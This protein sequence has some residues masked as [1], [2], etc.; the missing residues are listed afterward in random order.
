MISLLLL[1]PMA[2]GQIVAVHLKD[3]RTAKKYKKRLT[4]LNGELVLIGEAKSGITIDPK[5]GK[6]SYSTG[7]IE[8]YVGNP[9]DPSAVPYKLKDGEITSQ[10][11]SGVLAIQGQQIDRV[12]VLNQNQS[13]YGL[14]QEYKRRMELVLEIKEKRGECER[15]STEWHA[16]NR[17]LVHA[18]ERLGSWLVRS[19]YEPASKK[20]ER[21][22]KR[23][24]KYMAERDP[25][26]HLETKETIHFV[27]TS[28]N[29]IDLSEDITGGAA[30]FRIQ[31][32][33]HVRIT[34]MTELPDDL[35]AE[36][37]ELA[38]SVMQGFRTEFVDPY[39]QEGLEDHMPEGVFKEFWFG[40]AE[41][42]QYTRF[43]EEYYGISWGKHKEQRIKP[44][45]ARRRA[46]KGPKY[47]DYWRLMPDNDLE[48]IIVHGMGHALSNVHYNADGKGIPQAWIA[49]GVGYYLSLE[50][51]GRNAVTCKQFKEKGYVRKASNLNPKTAMLGT[52]DF[53]NT[54][55]LSQG[56][57]ID[58]LAMKH[59]SDMGDADLAKSWSFFDFMARKE[60]LR[61]QLWMRSACRLAGKRDTFI[62]NWRAESMELYEVNEG[63][64]FT[65]IEQR[66][67]KYAE[68][69]QDRT[70]NPRLGQAGR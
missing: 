55:A 5:S 15:K 43:F 70:S 10:R 33:K 29:L 31:E 19:G 57:R 41:D 18:Y 44:K 63:N 67:R 36:L 13:L 22:I 47:L 11:K 8:L 46:F 42:E 51:L 59:L 12:S 35:V 32:S 20:L 14:A 62:K 16:Q 38:E 23:H 2:S 49:E 25:K 37:L 58:Q 68:N 34:Y 24:K 61:G 48:G 40:P 66:W 39:L 52:R 65:I 64:V 28:D 60:G 50:F 1:A 54:L 69:G 53:Y 27:S 56:A 21:E 3:A 30:S 17:R 6:I 26:E 7:R 4:E 45:G 9:K